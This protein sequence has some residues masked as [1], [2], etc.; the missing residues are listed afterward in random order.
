MTNIF[1]FKS[2]SEIGG[3]KKN[4]IQSQSIRYL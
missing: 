4:E 2:I 3:G 1:Y